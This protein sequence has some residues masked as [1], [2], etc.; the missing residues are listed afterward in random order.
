MSEEQ[1]EAL[2]FERK[3]FIWGMAACNYCQSDWVAICLP[4][5]E[6]ALECPDCRRYTGELLN[7]NEPL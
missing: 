6:I 5:E 1:S 4:C 2:S 3:G 7:R